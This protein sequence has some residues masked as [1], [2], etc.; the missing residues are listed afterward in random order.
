[1]RSGNEGKFVSFVLELIADITY[2]VSGGFQTDKGVLVKYKSISYQAPSLALPSSLL[3][4]PNAK[5]DEKDV[6]KNLTVASVCF[7]IPLYLLLLN[8]CKVY[9]IMALSN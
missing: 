4:V 6:T 1:M 5:E 9:F 7:S 8:F 3:K 2:L